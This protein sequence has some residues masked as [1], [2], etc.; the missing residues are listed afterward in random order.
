MTNETL[1]QEIQRL[2]DKHLT[3]RER[4]IAWRSLGRNRDPRTVS[5]TGFR[6][7]NGG[8]TRLPTLTEQ[9]NELETNHPQSYL[10]LMM[11]L[12]TGESVRWKMPHFVEMSEEER[13]LFGLAER[14]VAAYLREN[15]VRLVNSGTQRL[16]R[17][18][19]DSLCRF[20]MVCQFRDVREY[21]GET[22]YII[23]PWNPV[24]VA[25][26][27][28]EFGLSRIVHSVTVTVATLETIV[29]QNGWD[30]SPLEQFRQQRSSEVT[31]DEYWWR[32][33]EGDRVVVKS[34]VFIP[35]IDVPLQEETVEERFDEL[36]VD[37]VRV[38]GEA[39]PDDEQWRS[40]YSILEP[41]MN[42]Y[43]EFSDMLKRIRKHMNKTLAD[44]KYELTAGG[45]PKADPNQVNKVDPDGV[46]TI[47]TY[48]QVRGD[49]GMQLVPINPFDQA[50]NLL[51]Q[52]M[53]IQKQQG[54]VPDALFGAIEFTLSGFALQTVLRAARSV[55]GELLP[56]MQMVMSRNGKWIL[57]SVKEN[58]GGKRRI[59]T[60][61]RATRGYLAE[62]FGSED[63]PEITDIQADMKLATPSDLMERITMARQAN[64]E[65]PQLFADITIMEQLFDDFVP[66][67]QAEV[68][69]IRRDR[70]MNSQTGILLQQHKALMKLLEDASSDFERRVYQRQIELIEQQFGSAQ[71]QPTRTTTG[72]PGQS[73]IP[74]EARAAGGGEVVNGRAAQQDNNFR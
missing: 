60:P 14:A 7:G 29:R 61:V 63:V 43:F 24:D 27:F 66:D 56:V 68:N 70:V 42:V 12:L 8:E 74:F 26:E 65:N 36:P 3:R 69:A 35:N 37:I 34:A 32:D 62:E 44:N 47:T 73:S 16:E 58:K 41:N 50:I 49:R 25:E 11:H 71:N 21:R 15:D 51:A 31:Y 45:V 28:D 48:D 39:F 46:G 67:S 9:G 10:L 57:D 72:A 38:N 59:I 1:R 18:I 22:K 2:K 33:I 64:P 52:A 6:S 20:G 17:A 5:G 54:S 19:A 4:Q 30:S 23:E 53:E 13:S 40:G 55:A